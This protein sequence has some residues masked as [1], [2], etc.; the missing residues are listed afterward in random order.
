MDALRD[1]VLMLLGGAVG[2]GLAWSIRC[3]EWSRRAHFVWWP[4]ITRNHDGR[5]LAIWGFYRK[6]S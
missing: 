6:L 2:F 4:R 1:A 5:P 3:A